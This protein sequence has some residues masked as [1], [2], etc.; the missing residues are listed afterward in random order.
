M[1]QMVAEIRSNVFRT[2]YGR[3]S[4]YIASL[5]SGDVRPIQATQSTASDPM[6]SAGQIT[7]AVGGLL[8]NYFL[9]KNI[10]AGDAARNGRVG[11]VGWG[12]MVI[13]FGGSVPGL[14]AGFLSGW[15]R[16]LR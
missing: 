7:G 2:R 11:G 16:C 3:R 9:R 4:A 10:R 13:A 15:G 1:S 5:P 14:L 12:L 6:L 8:A